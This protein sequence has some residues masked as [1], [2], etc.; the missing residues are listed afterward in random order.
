[1]GCEH[2]WGASMLG[3]VGSRAS[4]EIQLVVVLYARGG[5]VQLHH[6]PVE[7]P[8]FSGGRVVRIP[9]A[10]RLA[11]ARQARASARGLHGAVSQGDELSFSSELS[12]Y[13]QG[14]GVRRDGWVVC[15]VVRGCERAL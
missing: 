7:Q 6:H 15:A 5:P 13:V 14:V 4:R 3:V 12:I 1:M 2:A 9:H 11:Y 8:L 10:D